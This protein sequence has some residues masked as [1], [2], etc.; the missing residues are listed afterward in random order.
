MVYRLVLLRHGLSEYS[1]E[2]LC[3]GWYDS[4]LCE[5][6][7]VE[8]RRAAAMLAAAGVAPTVA[9]TSLLDR[10]IETAEIVLRGLGRSWV[11][12]R[13]TWRLNPMHW[14]DLTG[15]DKALMRK[16]RQDY[17]TSRTPPIREGNESNPNMSPACRDLPTG[18]LPRCESLADVEQRVLPYWYDVLVPDL[19]AGREVLLSAHG[20]S[21]TVLMKN[22]D[23]S[24]GDYIADGKNVSTGIPFLYEL[25]SDMAPLEARHPLE[26]ALDPETVAAHSA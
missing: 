22:L 8:A 7:R 10:A 20:I 21:L 11:D 12:I 9:H 1:R 25:G 6:G 16:W 13:R 23:R 18:L 15:Q 2:G 19:R 3:E 17:L 26:R 4:P 24:S 14:G 5:E